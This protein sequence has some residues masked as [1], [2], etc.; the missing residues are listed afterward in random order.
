MAWRALQSGHLYGADYD[1]ESKVLTVQFANGA[2]YRSTSPVPQTVVDT[3]FQIA[4][5]GS[6]YHMKLKAGY[7]MIRI[8]DGTTKSGRRSRRRF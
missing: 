1:E 5:P 7:G 4:S 8:A 2:I 6:Y 3:L